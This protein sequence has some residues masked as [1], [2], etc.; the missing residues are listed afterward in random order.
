MS[1]VSN[2][3]LGVKLLPVVWSILIGYWLDI[4]VGGI[5]ASSCLGIFLL[6]AGAEGSQKRL[7]VTALLVFAV[8]FLV[9]RATS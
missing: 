2:T 3:T 6:E 8:P 9:W 5:V 4:H 7:G 1:G